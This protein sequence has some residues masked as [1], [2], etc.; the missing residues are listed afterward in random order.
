[1][2]GAPARL[3]VVQR[4]EEVRAACGWITAALDQFAKLVPDG[5]P[6]YARILHP[7]EEPQGE[8]WEPVSWASVAARTGRTMHPLVQFERLV[9]GADPGWDGT[10][11]DI[12]R[13][14]D[15][16]L[17]ALLPL[18]GADTGTPDRCWFC[19][20]DGYG[21]LTGAV[22]SFTATGDGPFV[23]LDEAIASFHVGFDAVE[24]ALGSLAEPS[25]FPEPA[26]P[27][28]GWPRLHLPGRD[29]IVL[30]G[31]LAGAPDAGRGLTPTATGRIGPNLWWPDDRAWVVASEIDL[32]SDTVNR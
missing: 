29:Y 20:W 1:M 16:Q 31:P 11:P 21:D 32:D 17:S 5:Y 15:G 24:D 13:L 12:G 2:T 6:T 23:A 22:A 18:L 9:R 26:P 19:L 25:A 8:G 30:R 3:E 10:E 27:T 28:L 14:T 4:E 7:A